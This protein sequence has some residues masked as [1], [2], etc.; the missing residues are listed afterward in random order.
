MQSIQFFRLHSKIA[1]LLY[2]MF[3]S[4]AVGPKFKQPSVDLPAAWRVEDC[5]AKECTN[6]EWWKMFSDPVLDSLINK[7]LI[8]N[9]NI[10]IAAARVEQFT[11]ILQTTRAPFFPQLN[12]NVIPGAGNSFQT[13]VST[14]IP[15]GGGA[16]QPG[17]TGLRTSQFYQADLGVSWQL[18]LWGRLRRG[19][20]ASRANLLSTSEAKRG[21]ILTLVQSVANSYINLRLLDE[22][23]IFT[24]KTAE[25]W[26]EN[27]RL[28]S[29]QYDKGYLSSLEVNQ[30]RSQYQQALALI[31]VIEMQIAQQENVLSV[32]L[33]ENP[34]PIARGKSIDSLSC[35]DVPAGLPSTLLANRP[36]IREAQQNLIA[37]NAQIGVAISQYFPAISLTGLLGIAS[38]TLSG[39]FTGPTAIWNASAPITA[40]LFNWGAISGQV[41]SARAVE[42]QALY[43]YIQTV[44]NAFQDVDNAL[45]RHQK[46]REQLCEQENELESLRNAVYYINLQFTKG[47]VAYTNVLTEEI[48]LFQTE[49]NYIQTKGSLFQSLVNLY[50]AMGGGW[51]VKAEEIGAVKKK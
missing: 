4:C 41:K 36:D 49:L 23:L 29:L 14:A 26:G 18:D 25:N 3:L 48:S 45:V 44:Q 21:V 15:A 24:R 51:V 27:Y 40:P 20:E 6:T 46:T 43:T 16:R 8:Q 9:R 31:P 28:I 22:Q 7:A 33:G 19:V 37:S 30:A 2:L 42:K 11:G 50:A 34:G 39:L 47:Y 10:L 32:L 1:L 17:T 38:T 13:Q 35:P 5:D 12:A